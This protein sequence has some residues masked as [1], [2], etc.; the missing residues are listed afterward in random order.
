MANESKSSS[1]LNP[2]VRP[3]TQSAVPAMQPT[4]PA[5]KTTT[6]LPVAP[7][8]GVV[9]L[10]VHTDEGI[11]THVVENATVARLKSQFGKG[12]GFEKWLMQKVR[13]LLVAA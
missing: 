6:V 3:Q 12:P 8:K 5:P 13:N 2:P 7:A 11:A 1:P 9:L 10:H 4:A